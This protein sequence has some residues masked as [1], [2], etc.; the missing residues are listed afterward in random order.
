[1]PA[2]GGLVGDGLRQ[3]VGARRIIVRSPDIGA[4]IKVKNRA[5]AGVAC[6]KLRRSEQGPQAGAT[7]D[8]ICQEFATVTRLVRCCQERRRVKRHTI[9]V[10]TGFQTRLISGV[11]LKNESPLARLWPLFRAR[12]VSARPCCRADL[13]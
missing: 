9:L 10:T 4:V 6:L 2:T 11:A 3:A 5:A 12:P 8:S 13:T 1:M 7:G